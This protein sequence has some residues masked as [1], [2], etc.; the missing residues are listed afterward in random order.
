MQSQLPGVITNYAAFLTRCEAESWTKL[1][2][3]SGV[4]AIHAQL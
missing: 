4:D 2:K 1:R 3:M